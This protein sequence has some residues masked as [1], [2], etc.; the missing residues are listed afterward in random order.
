MNN[1]QRVLS[2]AKK[3][4]ASQPRKAEACCKFV[5]YIKSIAKAENLQRLPIYKIQEKS[6]LQNTEETLELCSYLSGH[7]GVLNRHFF[8]IMDNVDEEI[9][10]S[11]IKQAEKDGFFAH[12]ITG[13]SIT[14]YEQHI[15]MFFSVNPSIFKG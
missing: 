11:E 7:I 15:Y 3:D 14:D 4:L 6:G 13:D 9:S 1:I 12:P 5:H 2:E 10:A 8:L